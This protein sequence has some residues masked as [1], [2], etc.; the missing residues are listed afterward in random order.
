MIKWVV[1]VVFSF[2]LTLSHAQ[3]KGFEQPDYKNIERVTKDKNS[4]FYY[5][6]LFKRYEAND[7]NLTI[8][9]YRMLYYGYFFEDGYQSFGSA[10]GNND[11]VKLL[12]NKDTLS[13]NDR[14]SIIRYT[15]EDL[16]INPFSLRDLYR[17]YRFYHIL[18]NEAKSDLYVNKLEMLSKAIASTGD[19]RSDTSGLHVLSIDDEYTIVSMLGYEFGGMQKL[20]PNQC[21]YLTLKKNDDGLE[22]LYFDVKQIFAGYG[23]ALQGDSKDPV[24]DSK[25]KK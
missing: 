19:A 2:N 12:F 23:K 7:T 22:G 15:N 9:Q 21:D 14:R 25:N 11:S 6:K 3:D 1:V 17:L 13:D 18:G 24:K 20:T 10:T 16:K 8:Q 4:E 5:P